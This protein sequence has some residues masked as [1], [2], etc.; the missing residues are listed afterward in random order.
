MCLLLSTP[1]LQLSWKPLVHNLRKRIKAH[2]ASHKA[3]QPMESDY[4]HLIPTNKRKE[5]MAMFPPMKLAPF[6]IPPPLPKTKVGIESFSEE[7][8]RFVSGGP[9]PTGPSLF[10][11]FCHRTKKDPT[12]AHGPHTLCHWTAYIYGQKRGKKVF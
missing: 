10:C 6:H 12:A 4:V 3:T 11:P 2:P 8:A 5:H 9:A 1:F 7:R